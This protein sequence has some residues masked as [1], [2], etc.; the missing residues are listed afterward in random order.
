MVLDVYFNRK[1]PLDCPLLEQHDKLRDLVMGL[2]PEL[3]EYFGSNAKI[4][5]QRVNPESVEYKEV[6]LRWF[7]IMPWPQVSGEKHKRLMKYVTDRIK[8]FDTIIEAESFSC[9]K[10]VAGG[11]IAIMVGLREKQPATV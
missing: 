11:A 1:L 8:S 5:V 2:N 9:T 7:V 3:K 4:D 6:G 10:A